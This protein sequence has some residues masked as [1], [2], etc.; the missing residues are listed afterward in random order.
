MQQWWLDRMATVPR[1]CRRSSPSSGTTL[2]D[3]PGEGELGPGHV[4]PEPPL[5]H[6]RCSGPSSR[7]S[8]RCRVQ[9]AMLIFLDND[10]NEKGT[11]NEN[12][13]REL[14]ELFTLGVVQPIHPR[15]TS[16]RRLERGRDTTSTTTPTRGCTSFYPERH[17]NR[18]GQ[19]VH[20]RHDPQLGRPG[21]HHAHPH[22][23]TPPFDRPRATSP[24]RCGRS[25]PTRIRR[26]AHPRRVAG[27]A[28]VGLE[29]RRRTPS[30]ARS[31]CGP[32]STPRPRT[33]GLVRGP[34]GMGSS[35]ASRSLGHH[36]R[37]SATRSGGWTRH[38]PATLRAAERGR[39]EERTRTG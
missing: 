4:R 39:L 6:S 36:R 24:R 12:F 11:P 9:V 35:P 26:C 3:Q 32:S 25:S 28:F 29:P 23:R 16:W 19:D 1:R 17:D 2:R 14:M 8:S 13:A 21:H 22:R 30:C 38:G 20:G 27:S 37:G 10:P 15:P 31:S 7:S 5:P 33:K 34:G 18:P